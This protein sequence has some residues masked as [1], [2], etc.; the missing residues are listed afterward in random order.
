VL[1]A[2]AA[3]AQASV[4]VDFKNTPKGTLVTPA[5]DNTAFL[6]IDVGYNIGLMP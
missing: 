4:T 2:P 1:A 3:P 5:R 6:A